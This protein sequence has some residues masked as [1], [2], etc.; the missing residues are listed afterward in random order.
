[1]LKRKYD[2][3]TKYLDV[4]HMKTTKIYSNFNMTQIKIICNKIENKILKI[5]INNL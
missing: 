3:K 4:S 5:L 2:L 1:M